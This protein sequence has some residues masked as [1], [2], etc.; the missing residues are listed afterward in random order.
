[1]T[2]SESAREFMERLPTGWELLPFR[3]LLAEPLR[4][5]VYKSKRFHGRGARV[6]NM[7]EL[8]AYDFISD[9]DMKR[10]ELTAGEEERFRLH[11]GDL[12]FARRSL[13]LEGSGKCSIVVTPPETTAF[14]SSL[15]RARPHPLVANS[16]FLFYLFKSSL[17]RAIIASIATRTAVSGIR[18]SELT[19]VRLP[20]PPIRVQFR[21]ADILSTYDELI[22]NDQRRI[23]ILEEMARALYREWF[24][25]LRFP[26][27][28]TVPHVTSPVGPIP[29]GWSIQ[30]LGDLAE[31]VRVNI[32][33]GKLDSP[34]AYVGLEHIPRRSVTLD[35][36]ETRTELGSN[37]LGFKRGDVLFGKI[38]PYF[39]KACLAPFDGVCSADTI[40]IRARR[41]ERHSLVV[42]SVTSDEFVA[43]AT[44]TSNGSKMPRANWSV[45]ENYQVLVPTGELADRFGRMLA[46]FLALQQTLMFRSI[47]L[48]RSR[49]LLLPRLFS[50]DV[51]VGEE[52]A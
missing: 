50:G 17:G 11:D 27:H 49:D 18:S 40:V 46:D 37:K 21:I 34:T 16:R 10:V 51:N 3:A 1:M 9:Q 48:R 7:G 12:L 25:D 5:G 39:H 45:L 47:N 42:S 24:I 31:E 19:D 4:N 2:T 52:A 15:I 38:R 26:G 30:R 43:E 20:V 14:E 8:F 13:V 28:A 22:V 44:A 36:W 35:A 33:K 41:P 23:R 29:Q 32:P 6:V